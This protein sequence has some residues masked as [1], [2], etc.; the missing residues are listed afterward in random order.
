MHHLGR[1]WGGEICGVSIACTL[2]TQ[3]TH[4]LCVCVR[5]ISMYGKQREPTKLL[6]VSLTSVLLLPRD[7][8]V[9][10]WLSMV[11][12]T[13]QSQKGQGLN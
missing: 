10:D 8:L 1:Q 2:E 13:T 4:F 9:S 11:L 3:A 7:Y 6:L 5:H 12:P